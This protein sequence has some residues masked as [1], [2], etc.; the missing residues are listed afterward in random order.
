AADQIAA[1]LER[2]GNLGADGRPILKLDCY[3]L[4]AMCLEACPEVIFIPAHIW[5]P[6]YSVLGAFSRFQSME[7][8][9]GDLA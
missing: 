5:T 3:D 6:H 9:F 1:Q 7:E 4:L 2:I 8:C